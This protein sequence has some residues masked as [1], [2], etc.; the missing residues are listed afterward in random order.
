MR[1]ATRGLLDIP[2]Y[3]MENY[4]WPVFS[5]AG[6]HAWNSLPE[7]LRQT[8]PT[9]TDLFNGSENVFIRAN[10]AFSTLETFCL[11]GYISLLT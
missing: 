11:M 8:R 1:I 9:R 6:L 2:R 4:G 3:D 7:H 10:I 5:Y